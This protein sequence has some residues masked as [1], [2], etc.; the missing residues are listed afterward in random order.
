M[1][2]SGIK[3]FFRVKL[4]IN[5][6]ENLHCFSIRKNYY[7][8]LYNKTIV[9][10]LTYSSVGVTE[11]DNIVTPK[12]ITTSRGSFIHSWYIRMYMYV[13]RSFCVRY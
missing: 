12:W 8:Y 5:L 11:K 3:C 13:C 2:V 6:S 9:Y 1:H 7:T 4:I 10:V